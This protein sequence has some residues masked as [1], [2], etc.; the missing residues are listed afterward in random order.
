M[1]GRIVP[2]GGFP[3]DLVIAL[4]DELFVDLI[5]TLEEEV[6]KEV[7]GVLRDILAEID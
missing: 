2:L 1:S 4:S 6:G 3:A 5:G 7:G